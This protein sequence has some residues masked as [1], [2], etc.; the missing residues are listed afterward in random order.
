LKE[1]SFYRESK[2][3]TSFSRRICPF[4][5]SPP[6]PPRRLPSIAPFYGS[7]LAGFYLKQSSLLR[8][9]DKLL[10]Y[11]AIKR[12]FSISRAWFYGW[13]A[14]A[15][16]TPSSIFINKEPVDAKVPSTTTAVFRQHTMQNTL[17]TYKLSLERS[18]KVCFM[19]TSIELIVV[20]GDVV[21]IIYSFWKCFSHVF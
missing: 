14:L 8:L 18:L 17:W 15:L 13:T 4:S 19:I 11:P 16:I 2:N 21:W 1:Q 5:S 3:R 6:H 7:F 9:S 12:G 20:A 10:R